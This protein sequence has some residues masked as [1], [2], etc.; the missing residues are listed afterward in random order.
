MTDEQKMLVE[1]FDNKINTLGFSALLR[2]T[3]EGLSLEE[4]VTSYFQT[5]LAALDTGIAIWN[6]KTRHNAVRPF[7]A[8]RHIYK[9][10]E[11]TAWGG[12][13]QGTVNAITGNE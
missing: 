11:V 4:F 6:E 1:L 10:R 13:F 7:S 12:R 5:N 9:D 2:S 8:V 3:V